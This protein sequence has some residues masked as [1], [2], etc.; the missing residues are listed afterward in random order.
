MEFVRS[1]FFLKG[2][3]SRFPGLPNFPIP[4][5]SQPKA[6]EDFFSDREAES[7][8]PIISFHWARAPAD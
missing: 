2:Q 7:K 4:K 3:K 5:S 8:G 1:R 6:G